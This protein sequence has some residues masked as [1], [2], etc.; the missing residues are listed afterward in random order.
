MKLKN[1]LKLRNAYYAGIFALVIN[2]IPMLRE[3]LAFLF[4]FEI[5]SGINAVTVIAVL[6]AI[7]AIAAL[8]RKLG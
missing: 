2:A 5:T 1:Y 8:N 7:G 4:D 6:T 3:R